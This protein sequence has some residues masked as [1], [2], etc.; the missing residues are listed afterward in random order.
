MSKKDAVPEVA[1]ALRGGF[2]TLAR[3][4]ESQTEERHLMPDHMHMIVG[5]IR[6]G[7]H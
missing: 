7:E 6:H 5:G 1:K 3:Q 2:R 4:K